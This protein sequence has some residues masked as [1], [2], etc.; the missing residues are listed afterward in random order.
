MIKPTTTLTAADFIPG[1]IIEFAPG[2]GDTIPVPARVEIVGKNWLQ[3]RTLLGSR[4]ITIDSTV[5]KLQTGT[6]E[7]A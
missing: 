4:C 6:K 5:R 7:D 3:V 1:D 2:F